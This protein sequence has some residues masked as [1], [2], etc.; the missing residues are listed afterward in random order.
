M[1]R[2]NS[3]NLDESIQISYKY[4]YCVFIDNSIFKSVTVLTM[5]GVLQPL[6][7]LYHAVSKK[8][9][10]MRTGATSKPNGGI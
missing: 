2:L 8:D 4:I 10:F 3:M 6:F 1:S 5:I 7:T 9:I